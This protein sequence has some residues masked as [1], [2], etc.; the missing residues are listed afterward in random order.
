[1]T[2]TDYIYSIIKVIYSKLSSVND[3]SDFFKQVERQYPPI[4]TNKML[5]SYIDK[6]SHIIDNIYLGNAYTAANYNLLKELNI[7]IIINITSNIPNYF[8]Y[9]D[10]FTYINY[11]IKDINDSEIKEYLIKSYSV[12]STTTDKNILIHCYAGSSRSA[13]IILYYLIKK[14]NYSFKDANNML[15]SKRDIVN[16]NTTYIDEI[17]KL[18]EI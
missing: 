7:N 13:S 12:L 1:M 18:C 11:N 9:D 4:A 3:Y 17:K 5:Y 2:T 8:E 14:Y 16:I 10:H 15:K 6:P